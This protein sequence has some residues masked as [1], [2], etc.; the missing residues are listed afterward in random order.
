VIVTLKPYGHLTDIPGL[1]GGSLELDLPLEAG[2]LRAVLDERFPSLK[3]ARF[4][5]AVDHRLPLDGEILQDARELALL[6][7]ASGG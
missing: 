7:P 4:R 1:S 6:P 5:I 3:S 2:R